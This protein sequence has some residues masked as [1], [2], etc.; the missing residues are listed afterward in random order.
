[1]EVVLQGNGFAANTRGATSH[2]RRHSYLQYGSF[3]SLEKTF[4]F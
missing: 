1:M 3:A 2:I 4:K